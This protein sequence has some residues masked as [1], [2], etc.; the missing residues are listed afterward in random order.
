[1]ISNLQPLYDFS[2]IEENK[3]SF[4]TDSGVIYTAYF[5]VE[6]AGFNIYSFGFEKLKAKNILQTEK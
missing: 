3:Y 4:T 2:I 6:N 5:I 1:M